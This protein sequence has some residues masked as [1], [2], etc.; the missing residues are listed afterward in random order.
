MR[1]RPSPFAL[2]EAPECWWALARLERAL[3]HRSGGRTRLAYAALVRCLL[4]S[5]TADLA[6]ALASV[7]LEPS[8]LGRAALEP[9]GIPAGVRAAAEHDLAL[10][11]ALLARPWRDEA[12]AL[13]ETE[14]PPLERL[15]AADPQLA[16]FG[17][18]LRGA[19]A[20]ERRSEII[21]ALLDRYRDHGTGIL[22]RYRVFT[23]RTGV[24]E[25]VARPAPAAG[26]QLI[27]LQR[28][29]DLLHGNTEAFLAGLPASDVL[30]YGPRGSGKST[31]VRSLA[32]RYG[33]NGLRLVEVPVG[34][35]AELP[36]LLEALR[37][38]VHRYLLY[39]DDLSFEEGDLRYHPLK[40]LLEGT[41][42]ARPQR[43]LLYA[44]SNRRHLVRERFAD[45]PDPLD[46]D[47]HA[48]D[49]QHERLALADRFGL[50]ITFPGADQRRYLAIVQGLL[51]AEGFTEGAD[52]SI[53]HRAVRFADLQSGYSG[54]TARH[55]LDAL[56]AD[57]LP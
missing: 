8:A 41:V 37:P 34:R 18:L 35:L 1:P 9:D 54:R 22:A 53:L 7:L 6:T 45:R 23:W 24:L 47:V 32:H 30:L 36:R 11:A 56:K 50:T 38:G 26:D 46:D 42:G 3:E 20:P 10:L 51:E 40:T 29:L 55:F 15:A 17:R 5:E 33:A 4:D 14:L 25:G 19:Q 13:A 28:Q 49:T 21:A 16:P 57:R 48:W 31:A 39:I 12:A 43:V 52:E 44:T 2:F 27:G